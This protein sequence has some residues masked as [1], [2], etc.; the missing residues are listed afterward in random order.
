MAALAEG[1]ALTISYIN[2]AVERL[3]KE[4]DGLIR[5]QALLASGPRGK[6]GRLNFGTLDLEGKK[7]VASLFIHEIRLGGDRAEVVWNV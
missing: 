4:R 1:S 6:V 2:R 7:L 3:E 5:Q